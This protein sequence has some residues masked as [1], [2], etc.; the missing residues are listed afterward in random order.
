MRGAWQLIRDEG[1]YLPKG[2]LLW[3]WNYKTI[4]K[5]IFQIWLTF[6]QTRVFI[7]FH[8]KAPCLVHNVFQRA[9]HE[10]SFP[11]LVLLFPHW[12]IVWYYLSCAHFEIQHQLIGI[13]HCHYKIQNS[14]S[15]L[16]SCWLNI[17]VQLSKV[18]LCYT[19]FVFDISLTMQHI[20]YKINRLCDLRF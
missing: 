13:F 20:L 14:F 2:K 16:H 10:V 3:L 19:P 6:L 12:S 9:Y 17:Q 11:A 15:S 5:A 1:F 4:E 7:S 8:Q 18:T